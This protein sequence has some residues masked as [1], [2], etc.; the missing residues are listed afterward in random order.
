MASRKNPFLSSF[1]A[2]FV[3]ELKEASMG[4]LNYLLIVVL[5]NVAMALSTFIALFYVGVATNWRVSVPNPLY[6]IVG[7]LPLAYSS[8]ILFNL[9]EAFIGERVN[10]TLELILSSPCSRAGFVLGKAVASV[11]L[12]TVRAMMA[13]AIAATILLLTGLLPPLSLN[14]N[15]PSLILSIVLSVLSLYGVG[16]IL[17]AFGLARREFAY[18]HSIINTGIFFLSGY[19]YPVD[20]LPKLIQ[21]ILYI[22]PFAHA[23]ES[24]RDSIILGATPIQLLPH[25]T[26]MVAYTASIPLGLVAFNHIEQRAK[27]TGK[28]Y[29]V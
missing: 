17:A 24:I 13:M 3:K 26:V 19:M 7:L 15:V 12:E 14:V 11:L 10:H 2:T 1:Y 23:M 20:A 4:S 28:I 22:F 5:S 6:Q 21:E 8:G 16:L 25:Y 27:T 9:S 29:E 18:V